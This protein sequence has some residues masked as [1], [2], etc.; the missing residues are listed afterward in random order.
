MKKVVLITGASSG[1]G[2]VM[3]QYLSQ[4]GCSV[5]GT[6]R[7]ADHKTHAN[8]YKMIRM[9]V[10]DNDSIKAAV[11]QIIAVDNR[12]DV[13]I[14]N[15][16][17]SLVS[18]LEE[19]PLETM[20]TVMDVNLYGVL[21]VCRAVIPVMRQQKSG[22]IINVSSIAGL[23]GLPFRGVYS[24]SKFALEGLTESLSMEMKSFGISV[25][26]VEPGDFKTKIA[27]NRLRVDLES[28]SPYGETND[29]IEKTANMQMEKA[30]SPECMGPAVYN[31]ISKQK[32]KLRYRVGSFTEKLSVLLKRV[33]PGRIFETIIRRYYHLD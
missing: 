16:G 5:W 21:R 1:F 29:M 20:Q 30:A 6:S 18:P 12:I 26:M 25:C 27:Q 9:D 14:N 31:I 13:L 4:K 19:T 15:A 17:I 3:A 7:K 22:L 10:Q 24:A 11:D 8:E 2:K 28:T 23:M 32:P 33:I